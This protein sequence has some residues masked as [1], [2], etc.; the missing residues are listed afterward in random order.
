MN[1]AARNL[2]RCEKDLKEYEEKLRKETDR[3]KKV[4]LSMCVAG[5]KNTIKELREQL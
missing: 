3:K 4:H 5:L 2:A 1:D